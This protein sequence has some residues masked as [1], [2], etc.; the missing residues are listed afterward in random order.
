MT[1]FK[2]INSCDGAFFPDGKS[3]WPDTSL[4]VRITPHC[5]NACDFCI[6]A[7]DMKHQ[8]K[9]DI[10]KVVEE[11]LASGAGNIQIIGGEPLL[12]MDRCIEFLTRI[13]KH[14]NVIY[15]TT[16]IPKT[17]DT[18]WD[19]YL[20][21]Q[22]LVDFTTVSI[23]SVD[24]ELNNK[25]MYAK[26]KFD[27]IELLARMLGAEDFNERIT[28]NLNLVRG[29]VDT[30]AELYKTLYVLERMNTKKL[31]LNE[32]MG[33][34]LNYVNFEDMMETD[35]GS[36]YTAGCKTKLNLSPNMDVMLKRSCFL[37]E[38]SLDGATEDVEKLIY[39]KENP[40]EFVVPGNRVLYEHGEG[41]L[42][43]REGRKQLPLVAIK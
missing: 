2:P 21:V 9:F 7:E 1:K 33:A 25:L 28:V 3:V 11:T 6:A 15:L 12:F 32:L 17:I 41:D 16:A 20:E 4:S 37:V 34:P 38:S 22:R 19:K 18:Q 42:K 10:D 24:W 27:R 26:Q 39:K 5:D 43:W 30:A 23:Q 8:H 31:R 35:L 13:R 40:E 29:G 14:V 36:P